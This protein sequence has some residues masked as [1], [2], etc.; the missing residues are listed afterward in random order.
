MA[1]G[2]VTIVKTDGMQG[3][4]K[5]AERVFLYLGKIGDPELAGNV[6][7][8][9]GASDLDKLLGSGESELKTQITAARQNAQS[10][11]WVCYAFGIAEETD[12]KETL[13]TLLDKPSDLN[14]EAVVL[15][16]PFESKEEVT[17]AMSVASEVLSRFAKFITVIGCCSGI[18]AETETWGTY[19]SRISGL[20]DGV[21][22]ERVCI[23]PLLHGNDL[24]CV[25][26]R[27]CNP[28]VSIADSPMRVATG[29]L[30]GLGEAPVDTEANPLVMATIQELSGKRFCVPQWYPGYDGFYWADMMTLAAEASDFQVWE[31]LRVIDYCARRVRILA[32]ARI[33]DR[34]L[35]NTPQSISANE[36]YFMRPL[37]EASHPIQ[38]GNVELPAMI[39]PPTD[40]DI[41]ITWTSRTEVSIAITARPYNC[42]KSITVY[43]GLDLSN[44]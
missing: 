23:V 9:G 36:T 38:M 19:S 15:C 8:I 22:A 39:Q 4:F 35:N 43:L 13:Y 32:I 44:N 30:I 11:N 12:W 20:I 28:T 27:L 14:V 3:S 41:S 42:P 17:A 37:L 31:N 33:A 2:K 21:S 7:A 26:G 16:T 5:D 25:C 18:D 34:R 1:I 29:A 24:G 40:G 10:E 6:V